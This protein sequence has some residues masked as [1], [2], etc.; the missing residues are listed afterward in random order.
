MEEQKQHFKNGACLKCGE[1]GHYVRDCPENKAATRIVKVA[2]LKAKQLSD[3]WAQDVLERALS[4]W[5]SDSQELYEQ[6]AQCRESTWLE[7]N[8]SCPIHRRNWH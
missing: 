6:N 8:A 1:K 3:E 5:D 2:M 7:C 4:N